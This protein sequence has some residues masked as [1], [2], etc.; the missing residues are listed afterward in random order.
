MKNITVQLIPLLLLLY[1][2]DL[3]AQSQ[4]RIKSRNI[5]QVTVVETKLDKK[6]KKTSKTIIKKYD[7]K[8]VLIEE[9][10]LSS[11]GTMRNRVTYD[12]TK[13][14]KLS[15]RK[16]YNSKN[17]IVREKRIKYHL[18]FDDPIKIEYLKKGVVYKTRDFEYDL[19]GNLRCETT[20]NKRGE[21]SRERKYTCDSKG[22]LTSRKEINKNGTVE[23]TDYRYVY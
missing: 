18:L 6:G 16:H 12:Y 10:T 19:N 8:G 23:E 11:D 22:M 17:E 20:Y 15:V 5:K 1:I 14:G 7:R 13:N 2:T 4:G 9:T 21:K 3:N